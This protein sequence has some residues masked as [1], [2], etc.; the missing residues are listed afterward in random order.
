MSKPKLDV[1]EQITA[2]IVAAIEAGAGDYEM[3]WNRPQGS[4]FLPV[5]AQTRKP[6]RGVNTV[7]LWAEA[8]DKGHQSNEW[9]TYKQWGELGAQVQKGQ[10]ATYIVY[11]GRL[12]KGPDTI[13][14]ENGNELTSL[15]EPRLFARAYPVFNA[16]QVDGYTPAATIE[17][18]A[19]QAPGEP[20]EEAEAYFEA[21]GAT[22]RHGGAQAYYSPSQD[23]IQMP[24]FDTFKTVEGYYSVLAH[25]ATHWTG[26]RLGRDLKGRFGDQSYA[27]EELVAEL[28]AAFTMGILGLSQ[29]PRRDHA[30]YI[31]NWLQVLKN[32]K[33]AIFTASSQAQK[34]A[35]YMLE[36]QPQPTPAPEAAAAPAPRQD[37]PRIEADEDNAPPALSRSFTRPTTPAM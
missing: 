9:A 5:N 35:D 24:M 31:Q 1:Y 36:R 30:A 20:I 16:S 15:D 11:W 28:G 17:Q 25:E 13:T 4:G 7:A 32:D 22:I 2:Q 37:R 21:L 19:P 26:P 18:P 3:P 6:Y 23:A 27:M 29:E 8:Q 33:K 12:D 34:A 14:D 10:K